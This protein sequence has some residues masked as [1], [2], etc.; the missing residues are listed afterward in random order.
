M[1]ASLTK[2]GN[3]LILNAT[4]SEIGAHSITLTVTDGIDQAFYNFTMNIINSA[5]EFHFWVSS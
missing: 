3:Y 2:S 1:I 5:P 4:M